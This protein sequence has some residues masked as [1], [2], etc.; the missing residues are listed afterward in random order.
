MGAGDSVSKT[1]SA[2]EDGDYTV[3][4][5][6]RSPGTNDKPYA[7]ILVDGAKAGELE[8]AWGPAE[9]TS[10]RTKIPLTRGSHE[11]SFVVGDRSVPLRRDQSS[12][13]E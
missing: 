6:I 3:T 2:Y 13:R 12:G 5:W 1:I 10:R 4:A 8:Y 11:L 9:A 7:D